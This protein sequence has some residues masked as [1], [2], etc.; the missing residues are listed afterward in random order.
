[1][2]ILTFALVSLFTASSCGPR[3]PLRPFEV[4]FLGLLAARPLQ[5]FAG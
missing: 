4:S 2:K 3:P 5:F 1:M